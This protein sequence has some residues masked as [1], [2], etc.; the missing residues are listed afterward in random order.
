MVSGSAFPKDAQGGI[1]GKYPFIKVSDMNLAG[2]ERYITTANNWISEDTRTSLRAKVHP[3]D[4]T[5]F[6]KIGVALTYNR[7]RLLRLPTLIDNNMMSVV[8]KDGVVHPLFFYYLLCILDFNEVVVGT[9]LPYLNISDLSRIPVLIPPLK[10]QQAIACILASLDDKIELNRR[11]NGTLEATARAIFKSWFVDFDPVIDNALV[12]DKPIPECMKERAA[13]RAE[14]IASH[15][16]EPGSLN[17]PLPAPIANLFPN[18]FEDSA[19]GEIPKGWRV[20][21]LG[22]VVTN[23]VERIRPS[24]FTESVA[25]VPIECISPRTVCLSEFQPGTNA[26]SSLVLF[27]QGDILFGAMRPYFHKVCIAPFDGTTRTTAFVLR[28]EASELN[29]SALVVSRDETIEYATAHSEGSTIPY[30]KWMESLDSL[31]VVLPSRELRRRFHSLAEPFI[32]RMMN[33]VIE[34]RRLADLRD[35]LLPHLLSG[36]L[37]IANAERIAGRAT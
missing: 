27:K 9:A 30:A 37:P 10:E 21:T 22:D 29:Y 32:D 35:A 18:A 4:A 14:A 36:T 12:A 15:S 8:P 23:V 2:N 20:G 11:M 3:A 31:P 13:R 24:S 17:R 34:S 7:R 1:V 6:A 25:Y 28:P 33:A 26:R 16:Q 19:L 5:V